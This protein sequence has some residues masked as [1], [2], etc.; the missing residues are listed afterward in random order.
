MQRYVAA[1]REALIGE[2]LDPDAMIAKVVETA[3]LNAVLER[4]AAVVDAG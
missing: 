3:Y 2:S 1:R 4:F